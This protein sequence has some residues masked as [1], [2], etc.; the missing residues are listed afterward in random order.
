MR[1]RKFLNERGAKV[2]FIITVLKHTHEILMNLLDSSWKTCTEA[3]LSTEDWPRWCPELTAKLSFAVISF[4]ITWNVFCRA[5][6][7]FGSSNE[8]MS[9]GKGGLKKPL[10]A[11]INWIQAFI[12]LLYF[13][14]RGCGPFSCIFGM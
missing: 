4:K 3:Q 13:L 10:G 11:Q 1:E 14:R 7:L 9:G 6:S 5:L 8:L 12:Y 2:I